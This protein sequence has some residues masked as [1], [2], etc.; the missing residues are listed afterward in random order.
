MNGPFLRSIAD[1]FL[2]Y[3]FTIV[4]RSVLTILFYDGLRIDFYDPFLRSLADRFKRPFFAIVER[5][6]SIKDFHGGIE[7]HRVEVFLFSK[8]H[9]AVRC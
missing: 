2:Q 4:E 9:L 6:C 3:V 1:R 7:P 5:S 8:S